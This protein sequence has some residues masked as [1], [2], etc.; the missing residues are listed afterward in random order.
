MGNRQFG[1][2]MFSNKNKEFQSVAPFPAESSGEQNKRRKLAAQKSSSKTAPSPIGTPDPNAGAIEQGVSPGNEQ[3]HGTPNSGTEQQPQQQKEYMQTEGQQRREKMADSEFECSEITKYLYVSGYY[4]AGNREILRSNGITHIVNC[5]AAV[6]ESAFTADSSL[7]YL[8]LNMIDGRQDDISWFVCEVIQ[9][10][11]GARSVG[12]KVL[13][14]CEKGISRSCSYAIAYRIWATGD[15]WKSCF[16]F[17][18]KRRKVCAPNTAFT[19]NLIELGELMGKE[20]KVVGNLIL[21]CAYH[22]PH[23]PTTAVLKLCRT[24]ETRKVIT[25]CT[26]MLDPRGVFVIRGVVLPGCHPTLN[27]SGSSGR[28]DT[29]RHSADVE[30]HRLFIWQGQ[31]ASS[32]TVERAK[33]LTALMYGVLTS[34]EEVTHVMQGQESEVFWSFFEQNGPYV[35]G[36]QCHSAVIPNFIIKSSLSFL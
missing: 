31:Q 10:I 35:S 30:V 6:V 17:V 25:P 9:F 4:V 20:G 22:L 2:S 1:L 23:D 33:A 36:Q 12:G 11:M 29:G 7:K 24:P 28:K 13:I 5:S 3:Q 14:H 34:S 21:R 26:N 16:E 8:S 18:K 32:T 15:S 19:C 27:D